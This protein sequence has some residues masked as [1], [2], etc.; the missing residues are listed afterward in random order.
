MCVAGIGWSIK[1]ILHSFVPRLMTISP[2]TPTASFA[3]P[4]AIHHSRQSSQHQG[5]PTPFPC[6]L[7]WPPYPP[8]TPGQRGQN[9]ASSTYLPESLLWHRT[10]DNTAC[11]HCDFL[12][13]DN[14]NIDFPMWCCRPPGPCCDVRT[15]RHCIL[16]LAASAASWDIWYFLVLVM[17]QLG[18]L[19]T[20]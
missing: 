1:H 4:M 7:P 6:P 10:T 9:S 5:Q 18:K 8:Q 13:K 2:E 16:V 12:R 14:Q 11:L 15:S 3:Q 19:N 20:P 17:V